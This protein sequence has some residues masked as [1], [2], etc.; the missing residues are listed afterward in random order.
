MEW[1][2]KPYISALDKLKRQIVPIPSAS[3]IRMINAF[4]GRASRG[5][6]FGRSP[7]YNQSNREHPEINPHE[8]S[9]DLASGSPTNRFDQNYLTMVLATAVEDPDEMLGNISAYQLTTLKTLVPDCQGDAQHIKQLLL[10]W[11]D[12]FNSTIFFGHSPKR[13]QSIF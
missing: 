10:L 6:I 12:I 8:L 13:H 4:T 7:F 9:D 3:D 2:K 1:I 5:G 11:F